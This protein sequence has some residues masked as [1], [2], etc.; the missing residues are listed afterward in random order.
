MK[1]LPLKSVLVAAAFL[2]ASVS[3]AGPSMGHSGPPFER[4]PTELV[5]HMAERLDLS[6]D[7]QSRITTL[8]EAEHGQVQSDRDQLKSLRDQLVSMEGD[9]DSDSTR[10]ITDE[11]GVISG[12]LAYSRASTFSEINQ[13]LTEDQRDKLDGFMQGRTGRRGER[14]NNSKHPR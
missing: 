13:I 5:S 4:D 6:D 9:F 8:L 7:Q 3:I 10:V 14:H 11:M 1:N 2:V 12:R